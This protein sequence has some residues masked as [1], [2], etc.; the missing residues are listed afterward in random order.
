VKAEDLDCSAWTKAVQQLHTP[1][2]MGI[3]TPQQLGVGVSGGIEV[4]VWGLELLYEKNMA[5]GK[6]SCGRG[7]RHLERTQ[8]V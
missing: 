4:K 2:A 5:L 7:S 6:P 3:V 8:H 1:A